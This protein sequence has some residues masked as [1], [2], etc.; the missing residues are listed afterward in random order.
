MF[1]VDIR[2][3]GL[4]FHKTCLGLPSV[5]ISA[6]EG[7]HW[8]AGDTHAPWSSVIQSGEFSDDYAQM[9]QRPSWLVTALRPSQSK[10]SC[11]RHSWAACNLAVF[12]LLLPTP[13]WYSTLFRMTCSSSSTANIII[14]YVIIEWC[15][16]RHCLR[17]CSGLLSLARKI[18]RATI[19]YRKHTKSTKSTKFR[20]NEIN[21]T[22]MMAALGKMQLNLQ[23]SITLG[24]FTI[25]WLVWGCTLD[26]KWGLCARCLTL[27]SDIV[28][29]IVLNENAKRIRS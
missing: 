16:T 24:L 22:D 6:A 20:T 11:S 25:Y 2:V 7:Q 5:H 14:T 13:G 27:H 8:N 3:A 19:K 28:N 10:P 12:L 23:Y 18:T 21:S 29:A 15:A 17:Y 1:V 4:D 9:S 26:P